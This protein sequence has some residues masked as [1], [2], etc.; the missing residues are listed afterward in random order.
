MD[1]EDKTIITVVAIIGITIIACVAIGFLSYNAR[2]R[3]AMENGYEEGSLPGQA[4]AAW[5]KVKE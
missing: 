5:V 1:S 3:T 4:A 2:L